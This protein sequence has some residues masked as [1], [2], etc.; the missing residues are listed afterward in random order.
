MPLFPGGIIFKSGVFKVRGVG[1]VDMGQVEPDIGSS[2]FDPGS[3]LNRNFG[4]ENNLFL[5][6]Q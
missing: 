4:A 2:F 6:N 1:T 5:V 3:S